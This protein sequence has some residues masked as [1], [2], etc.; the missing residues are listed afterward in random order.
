MLTCRRREIAI[1]IAFILAVTV[2]VLLMLRASLLGIKP[3]PDRG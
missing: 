1:W 3:P 2:I